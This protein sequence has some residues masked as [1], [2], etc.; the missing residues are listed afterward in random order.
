MRTRLTNV[1][2][3]AVLVCTTAL[4]LVPG[5]VS[6]QVQASNQQGCINA[7]NKETAKVEAT[8]GKENAKCVKDAGKGKLTGTA[9]ACLTADRKGKV[10]KAQQKNVSGEASRCAGVAPDF[11]YTSATNGNAVAVGEELDLLHDIYGSDLDAAV[12]NASLDKGGASCQAAVSKAYEKLAVAKKKQFLACKKSGLSGK[13]LPQIASAGDL[14]ECISGRIDSIAGDPKGK[15]TKAVAKLV[16]TIAKKCAGVDMADAF[17]GTCAGRALIGEFAQCLDERVECRVCLM[18]NDLDAIS[19]DCDLFDNGV[20]DA[21][22]PPLPG[23]LP[24]CNT[25]PAA[26]ID[27]L[28]T[29]ADVSVEFINPPLGPESMTLRG[30]TV[31]QR[32]NPSDPGDGRDVID[33]EIIAMSLT[34]TAFGANIKMTESPTLN[35]GGQIKAQ[36]SSNS[37]PADSF[38]DVFVE[39]DTPIG[40]LHNNDPLT[41]RQIIDCIPPYRAI[42]LPA[43]TLTLPLFN[44]Q[45]QEVARLTHAKHQVGN[46]FCG[47]GVTDLPFEQCDPPDDGACPGG[48]N[49]DC[50]C[51]VPPICEGKTCGNFRGDCNASFPGQ[52]FCFSVAEGGGLCVDDFL[53]NSAQDCPGGS[54]DCPAGKTCYVD[55]CCGVPKCGPATCTGVLQTVSAVGGGG[56]PSASGD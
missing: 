19:A 8:Q 28:D 21:S 48:C 2:L 51:A 24:V 42:Y 43:V 41:M 12:I 15:I 40:R 1:A 44:G 47:N 31:I 26:G 33:T 53:C 6:A 46:P 36:N 18:L 37:F 16:R 23:P 20:A 30:P 45:G 49:S 13:A 34:G 55:T 14:A 4:L 54:S 32:G 25:F 17:P 39:I 52:C 38:F 9:E 56:G 3:I 10:A 50:T 5:N 35:S 27:I 7:V 29:R 22:C 11:G